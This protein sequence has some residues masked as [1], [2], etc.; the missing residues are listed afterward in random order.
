[1]PEGRVVLVEPEMSVKKYK[2]ATVH[3]V[4]IPFWQNPLHGLLHPPQCA[5]LVL[6]STHCPLQYVNPLGQMHVPLRQPAP[7]G[8]WMLQP[9]QFNGSVIVFTQAAPHGVSRHVQSEL[10]HEYP[11][12]QGLAH[13]PQFCASVFVSTHIPLQTV[14]FPGQTHCPFMHVVAPVHALLHI[15][16]CWL[17]VILSMQSTPHAFCG[18]HA[19][20]PP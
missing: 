1:M 11:G 4:H 5:V 3:G 15:P 16:Q 18:G 7:S 17:L 6:V 19:H 14:A 2:L 8:H 10:E 13:P 9:P 12:A 20:A